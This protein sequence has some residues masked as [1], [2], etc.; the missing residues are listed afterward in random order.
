VRSRASDVAAQLGFRLVAVGGRLLPT[1]PAAAPYPAGLLDEQS[2]DISFEG[3][4]FYRLAL[5]AVE[6]GG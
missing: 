1:Y 2:L 4:E 6:A 3:F 5:M